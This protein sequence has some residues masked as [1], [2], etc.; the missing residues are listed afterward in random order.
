MRLTFK[1]LK[2]SPVNIL[3]REGYVF[4]RRDDA[5]NEMSFV[6]RVG[7]ADYPRFHIYVK[8]NP[9]GEVAVNLHLDQKKPSYQGTAAHS[10][11]YEGEILAKEARLIEEIFNARDIGQTL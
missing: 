7:R 6:K 5:T 11:E 8:T 10:G 1:N 4:L 3:R 9:N 2:D